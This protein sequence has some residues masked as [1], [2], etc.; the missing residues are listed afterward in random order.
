MQFDFYFQS[1]AILNS[2]KTIVSESISNSIKQKRDQQLNGS[3]LFSTPETQVTHLYEVDVDPALQCD[4]QKLQRL[5]L[6]VVNPAQL[7][8]HKH[9]YLSDV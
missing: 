4:R 2:I 1:K 8:A 5:S 9:P 6:S 3:P 7:N